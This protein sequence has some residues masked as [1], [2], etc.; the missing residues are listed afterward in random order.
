[1]RKDK[2][3]KF[4]EKEYI[5]SGRGNTRLGI[6]DVGK[7]MGE[8][9]MNFSKRAANGDLNIIDLSTSKGKYKC[10]PYCGHTKVFGKN[11]KIECTKCKKEL[12][13]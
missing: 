4:I 7:K 1:M 2:N 10:C 3:L 5:P 6:G 13:L 12:E 9:R 11:S 8:K